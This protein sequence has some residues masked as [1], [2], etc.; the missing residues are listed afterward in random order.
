LIET[1][2]AAECREA[3]AANRGCF[4]VVELEPLR[5]E[6][7]LDLLFELGSA[8]GTRFAGT[9]SAVVTSRQMRGHEWLT[10]EL[11]A[12]AFIVSPL[13]LDGLCHLAELHVG[14]TSVDARDV[15]QR[16]WENLPWGST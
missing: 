9:A 15:K 10:R 3:A 16:I 6:Q 5:A 11:G 14:R 8:P 13:D 12:L 1:R 7:S 2:S 4:V